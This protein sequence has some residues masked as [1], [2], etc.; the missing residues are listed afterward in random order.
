MAIPK[1]VALKSDSG[2]FGSGKFGSGK[3]GSG[4]YYRGKLSVIPGI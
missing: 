2:K 1:I 3:F 4:K